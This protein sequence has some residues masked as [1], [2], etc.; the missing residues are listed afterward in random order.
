MTTKKTG[1]TG[2]ILAAGFSSRM[3]KNAAPKLKVR[4]GVT[5]D[6][7]SAHS[8]RN[9]PHYCKALLT[10]RDG[11]TFLEEI[12]RKMAPLTE[13]LI[14]VL[15]SDKDDILKYTNLTEARTAYVSV[16]DA[17]PPARPRE[18]AGNVE[19]VY[20]EN[21]KKGMFSSLKKG[22]SRVPHGNAFMINPVDCPVVKKETYKDLL[23]KWRKKP[24]K[25]HIPSFDGRRGH[26]AIYPARLVEEILKSPDNLPGGLK[27]F[28]EREKEIIS[29]VDTKDKGVIMDVDTPADY[30]KMAGGLKREAGE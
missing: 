19:I 28:L 3:K 10:L 2:I 29:Y 7:S 27:F 16:P 14:V 5:A 25:I 20:N 24:E 13:E 12:C 18:S 17:A 1:V 23:A 22:L 11:V 4:R 15:G 26:P 9:R 30:E 6:A 8:N 21:Y